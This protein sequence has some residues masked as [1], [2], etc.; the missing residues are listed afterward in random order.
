MIISTASHFG[1]ATASGTP[2]DFRSITKR[3]T[4][5]TAITTMHTSSWVMPEVGLPKPLKM[6]SQCSRWKNTA[7]PPMARST[8]EPISAGSWARLPSPVSTATP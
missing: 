5:S 6:R 4:M 1:A 3:A 7:I 8:T 2:S